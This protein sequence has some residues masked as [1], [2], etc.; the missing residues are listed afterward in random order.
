MNQQNKIALIT[1]AAKRVGRVIA[2]QMAAAGWDIA[3]HYGKSKQDALGVISQIE[4][5]GCRVIGIEAD[6]QDPEEV[7]KILPECV[8]R[9]GLPDCLINNAALFEYDEPSAF[10]SDLL[11]AHMQI[12]VAAPLIL[13]EQLYQLHAAQTSPKEPAVIIHL[14]DQKLDNLNPDFF[15]YTMS[16]AA[17][18][19]AMKMQAL[20]FAPKLRVV[21]VAPGITMISGDQSASSFQQAHQMTPLQRSSSPEDIAQGILYVCSAKAMTG[22]TLQIDGGQHLFGSRRD[23]MFLTNE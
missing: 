19:A 23:V 13:S 3:I 18:E 11:N 22:T 12:N 2:L 20:H 5:M 21:G 17:L 8:A 1:G 4:D 14:L 10:Q 16:K 15:S 9:L 6:L 7:K